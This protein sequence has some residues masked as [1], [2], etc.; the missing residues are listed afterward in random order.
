M[1]GYFSLHRLS[2]TILDGHVDNRSMK[3]KIIFAD[4]LHALHQFWLE[5]IGGVFLGF[6]LLFVVTAIREYRKYVSTGDGMF[7]LAMAAFFSAL[8]LLFALDSFRKARKP[9]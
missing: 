3:L 6:G 8:M 5:I 2:V 7:S 9:R 1:V 4:F